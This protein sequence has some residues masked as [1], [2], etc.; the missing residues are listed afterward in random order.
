L[1]TNSYRFNFLQGMDLAPRHLQQCAALAAKVRVA[2][3][4]RPRA[5]FD[6]EGLADLLLADVAAR[7]RA[8]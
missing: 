8:R 6:I 3:I 2:E 5:G 4:S 7:A 1:R